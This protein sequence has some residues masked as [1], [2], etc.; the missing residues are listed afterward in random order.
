MNEDEMENKSQ[1]LYEKL[2]KQLGFKENQKLT[3]DE[4][5]CASIAAGSLFTKVFGYYVTLTSENA[6]ELHTAIDE[7]L[8]ELKKSVINFIEKEA[9]Q[10]EKEND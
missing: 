6:H 8:Y 2:Q 10:Q 5:C 7:T 9:E 4:M 1:E 3:I